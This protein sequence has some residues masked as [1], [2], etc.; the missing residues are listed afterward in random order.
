MDSAYRRA[1][2][3]AH[4]ALGQA[5]AHDGGSID[6]ARLA[7]EVW[8]VARLVDG[9]A[10]LR[11]SLADPSREGS[12]R[13]SLAEK[14]L[15]GKVSHGT[16]HVVKNVVAQRWSDPGAV[17]TALQRLG[18]E[19]QLEH[20]ERHGRL[21]QVEDELFRF[22]RIVEGTP[23]LQAALSDRRAQDSAKR[24]LVE[25]L[26]SIK[27]APE[28]VSLAVQA[29]AGLRGA[30]FDRS[31]RAF[32]E[33]ASERQQQVNAVVTSAIPLTE[34]QL[35]TLRSA[36][37]RQYGRQVHTNVVIDSDVVGGIRVEIGDEV[38]DGTISHRLAEAHRRMTG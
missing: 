11:R 31:L 21:T 19:S 2:H 10:A 17:G 22:S 27:A 7:D 1:Y 14:V 12:E 36:L 18:V 9:N 16:V 20:A 28:T 35:E 4:E 6:P 5:L 26:L 37:S 29:V 8:A 25:R 38:V 32:Q 24:S 15:A 34:A 30:R 33:Q 3:N 23:D 13:A